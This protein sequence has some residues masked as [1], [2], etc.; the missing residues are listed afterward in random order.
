MPQTS[1]KPDKSEPLEQ[2][3]VKSPLER[4]RPALI[5]YFR[6]RV[7][8]LAEAEDLAQEVFVRILRR[9]DVATIGD[10]R[11][12][13]FEVALSVLVDRTRRDK[14]HRKAEHQSFDLDDHGAEDFASDRIYLGKE[15]LSRAAAALQELPDRTRIIFVLRRLE[16]MKYS[17]IARRLGISVSAVEKQMLRAMSYLT[18]RL[19][20]S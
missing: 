15:A 7:H 10:V 1:A 16:G 12:Y 11:A 8:D 6:R 14:A 19:G 4:Y 20:D 9:G 13:L 18:E 2:E 17:E 5:G 3:F